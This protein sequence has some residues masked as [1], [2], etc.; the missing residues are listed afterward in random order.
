VAGEW[1]RLQDRHFT[2]LIT[3]KL[4]EPVG[5]RVTRTE[6]LRKVG[7]KVTKDSFFMPAR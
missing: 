1:L 4:S 5:V 7:G 3:P 2:Y 6:D